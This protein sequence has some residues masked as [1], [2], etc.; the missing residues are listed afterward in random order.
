MMKGWTLTLC[1]AALIFGAGGNTAKALTV[2]NPALDAAI[3]HVLPA[4]VDPSEVHRLQ[5][6]W[7]GQA[8]VF[9]DYPV[10]N[11]R[12]LKAFVPDGHG[13]RTVD[14]DTFEEEGGTAEIT[15]IA[16]ANA[17]HDKAQELIVLAAWP[18]QHYDVEGT[19]Y[20]V[21]AFD[22]LT[23]G[24]HPLAAISKHFD[25]GCDCNRRDDKPETYRYKTIAAIR[26]ELTRMGY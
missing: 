19:L 18:V 6:A 14:I 1:G 9:I 4:G 10:E 5:T 12:V 21:R 16:F 8:I 22:D 25:G 11:D 15:A 20:E 3:N 23:A 17:D 24:A 26:K 13:Y 7:N 2:G